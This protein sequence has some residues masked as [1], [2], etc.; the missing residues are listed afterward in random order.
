MQLLIM[1][2]KNTV[3][4]TFTFYQSINAV[5]F[6]SYYNFHP[7][8][9]AVNVY[10]FLQIYVIHHSE[11][12]ACLVFLSVTLLLHAKT[13]HT[14]FAFN[15][16]GKTV[17]T[18]QKLIHVGRQKLI[19][20]NNGWINTLKIS[21]VSCDVI[22]IRFVEKPLADSGRAAALTLNGEIILWILWHTAVSIVNL[23]SLCYFYQW[24]ERAE[25]EL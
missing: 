4:V 23:K 10:S 20:A 15:N 14:V 19:D 5:Q 6:Y 9:T 24:S 18:V 13:L 3:E 16:R 7:S 8:Q 1:L 2:L 17:I 12:R 11:H 22:Y 25:F 21:V